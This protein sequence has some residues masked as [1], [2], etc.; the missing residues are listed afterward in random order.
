MKTI[1]LLL[2]VL[3]LL[4]TLFLGFTGLILL[5][6]ANSSYFRG[7]V[8][9]VL[10]GGSSFFTFTGILLIALSISLAL[11]LSHLSARRFLDIKMG[12]NRLSIQ[13]TVVEQ[14][15]GEVWKS[16]FPDREISHQVVVKKNKIEVAVVL[17]PI[18]E[19]SRQTLLGQ[20]ER[21]LC[22]LF[23][24]KL[25]YTDDFILLVSFD[26]PVPA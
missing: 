13:E 8:M 1:N 17:P 3:S 7:L 20:I 14:I 25:G 16:F 15:L 10:Q 22:R 26:N 23:E 19:E 2:S 24:S 9:H 21:H 6:L 4:F 5:I 12:K 18:E 11:T